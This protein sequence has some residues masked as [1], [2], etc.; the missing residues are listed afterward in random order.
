[1]QKKA[2]IGTD[3]IAVCT[4]LLC[5]LWSAA[6]ISEYWDCNKEYFSK[7]SHLLGAYQD[8]WLKI[9]TWSGPRSHLYLWT[10]KHNQSS[11]IQHGTTIMHKNID[12]S[13][14]FISA[15]YKKDYSLKGCYFTVCSTLH[16]YWKRSSYR[17]HLVCFFLLE[18]GCCCFRQ[19]LSTLMKAPPPCWLRNLTG[20]YFS[21]LNSMKAW[22][23]TH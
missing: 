4:V 12:N 1:M 18:V 22:L 11:K 15:S 8:N 9:Q 3:R 10:N 13:K 2:L 21:Q 7:S 19:H 23:W 16:Q 20:C 6:R 5:L 14:C 17:H